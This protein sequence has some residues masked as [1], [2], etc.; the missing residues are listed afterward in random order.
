[1][2]EHKSSKGNI[3]LPLIATAGLGIAAYLLTRRL[4]TQ[5]KTLGQGVNA[6]LDSCSSALANLESRIQNNDSS[7]VA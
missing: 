2:S 3:L 7:A 1:M 4:G 5:G 6:I